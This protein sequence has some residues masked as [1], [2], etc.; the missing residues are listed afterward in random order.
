MIKVY[1]ITGLI[2]LSI[3]SF[4][5]WTE[6]IPVSSSTGFH[7]E[8]DMCVDNNG[9]IHVV[10]SKRMTDKFWKILYSKSINNGE[11]WSEEYDISQNDTLWM[12]QP[13]IVNDSE[14]NLYVTYDYDTYSPSKMLVYLQIYDNNQWSQPILV[15]EGMTGSD[16]NKVIVDNDDKIIIGWYRNSKY[17]YRFFDNLIFSDVY[18]PYCD[19][20][21]IFLPVENTLI[22]NQIMKWIGASAS[23]NYVGGR[24]QYYEHDLS[25]NIWTLPEMIDTNNLHVGLDI[26]KNLNDFPE[27]D[28]RIQT[29]VW[30]NPFS[31]ATYYMNYDGQ[32]FSQSE[33]IVD[34]PE[35]QQIAIDQYNRPHITNR[36]KTETGQQLVHYRKINNEW[37]G[38]IIDSSGNMVHDATLLFYNN[39]LYL[40]YFKSEVPGDLDSDVL[41][42]KYDVITEIPDNSGFNMDFKIFP[43]PI[44]ASATF[45]FYTKSNCYVQVMILDLKGRLKKKLFSG[46]MNKGTHQLNWNI[47]DNSESK[48]NNGFY[49]CR[50]YFGRYVITKSFEI[51]E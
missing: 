42:T 30:P 23:F 38:Y 33:L 40:N 48:L 6:P 18:C 5:Q 17:Y 9:I 21:D 50:L 43:N 47:S 39:Y 31:D 1:E 34:D 36:E 16:Y 13:H 10:W 12:S 19:S 32:Q 15:T 45:E 26:T 8:P 22:S 49:L 37:I 35:D 2:L 46:N 3:I 24:L 4:A 25:D 29:S 28:Y 51:I 7:I 14:N 27:I 20:N 11:N 41:F 44:S